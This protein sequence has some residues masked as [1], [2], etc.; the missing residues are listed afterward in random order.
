MLCTHQRPFLALSRTLLFCDFLT[1]VHFVRRNIISP[2]V[3]SFALTPS[4]IAT[5]SFQIKG[6]VFNCLGR[7]LSR[8]CRSMKNC[9][10]CHGH[11]H[12]L[13]HKSVAAN[14]SPRVSSQTRQPLQVDATIICPNHGLFIL[15]TGVS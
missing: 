13:L 5:T 7:H 10:F 15:S 1:S 14:Q 11:H 3:K 8:D 2:R 4:I 6:F 9:S 12:T